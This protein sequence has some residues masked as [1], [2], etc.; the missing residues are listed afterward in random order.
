MDFFEVART[1]KKDGSACLAPEFLVGEPT[2]F[3]IRG[4]AFYAIWDEEKGRWS[5]RMDDVARLVDR[6]VLAAAEKSDDNPSV[7]LMRRFKSGI[8]REFRSWE[9]SMFDHF[10]PLD[11]T[12]VFADDP[13]RKEDYASKRL[14]YSLKAGD[15]SA[16]DRLLGVLYD[17]EE[18]RKIIWAIGSVISGDSARIQKFFVLYGKPG[19]GKSTI[20]NIIS[21]LFEGYS[22]PF[23]SRALVRSNNQFALEAF[24]TNPLIAID[25][26][27]DMSRLS[28]NTVLNSLV[29]HEEMLVNEK[30]KSL[31][32]MAFRTTLFVGTNSPVRITDSKSG[33]IR[34]LIDIHPTGSTVPKDTYE[35]LMTEISQTRG[36]IAAYCRD[37]YNRMGVSYYDEY[38]PL[39]MMGDTDALYNFVEYNQEELEAESSISLRRA[40]TMYK[41]YCDMASVSSPLPMYVFRSQFRSYFED[42]KDRASLPDGSRGRSVYV[43]FRSD[44][45][46]QKKLE[47]KPNETTWL[48]LSEQPSLLDRRY[49]DRPAQY[50]SDEGTPLSRW[51]DVTTTLSDIDTRKEHYVR[52]PENEIVIDFDI[53]ENGVKSPSRNLDAASRWPRTY[54]ERSRGGGGLHLHYVY[55]GDPER[56]AHIYEP[57]IEVKW[58]PGRSALRRR[59]SVCN[60]IPPATLEEGSLPLKEE[61]MLNRTTMKDEKSLRDLILRNLRKEIHPGTK[62]S[63]DFIEK[64]LDDAY[65]QGM[66]YDLSDMRQAVMTFALRSTHHSSYCLSRVAQMHF[67]SEMDV[68]KTDGVEEGDIVFFDC[69]V[70]P[71]LFLVNWKVR[72]NDHIHRMINPAPAEIEALVEH[73]L[74]GFNNR[75]YD[76]HILYGRMMGYSNEQ[77]F[78]LSQKIIGNVLDAGFRN[79]YDLSYSDIYDFSSKKQSLKKWEIE[80]GIHHK[81]LGLPWD[82]PVPEE[83]WP[84]VSAYCDNDVRAT[85]AVFNARHEDWT[86]RRVLADVAGMTPNATNRILATKII[87]GDN[88]HPQ[89]DLVYTDL[90]KEFPGYKYEFG[91]SSYRG[92]VTGEGGYVYAEPGIHRNVALLDIASMHPTSIEVLNMFGPYTKRFSEIK[93]ARIAIKHGDIE[94]AKSMLGGALGPYLTDA[95]QAKDLAYALKIVINSVYGLTAAS[96]DNAFR[97]PRNVDNI[98]AKRG[99]LFMIDLKHFV[100]E[101]GFT[102]AHIKTDSIKIPDATPEIISAVTEFGKKYGYTFEHE[103]TYDRMC[104]LND[105]V[106]IAHDEKGW[107]ATGAQFLHPY[108]F[109]SLFSHEEVTLDDFCETKAVTTSLVLG[110]QETA[111]EGIRFVGRVG[112]F[113]PVREG[114]F[115]ILREKEGKYSFASGSKGYKWL[116]AEDLNGDISLVDDRYANSLANKARDAISAF[117]DAD[118]FLSQEDHGS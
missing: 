113:V 35:R 61:K 69:E 75:R 23:D 79:A 51:D 16:F 105:A 25:H 118:E 22:K 43:G 47:E 67:H 48:H 112:R 110:D 46:T 33:I 73:R 71:N 41:E 40:Y 55:A 97:D 8:W 14:P 20:L 52:P 15:H 78:H 37:E 21:W 6:E 5:T 26:D 57:G 96:F 11:D 89:K 83:R 29:S 1:E 53:C 28:D 99:A 34:R 85:E 93:A 54:A 92:E 117:G 76:N 86:A 103:A 70:F 95:S 81:E 106:Y 82:M 32:G 91:V 108:V 87:F 27:G 24:K 65:S 104:L 63:I 45:L 109:K 50:S 114:G 115:D 31:Y 44:I 98:C 39:R 58:Y 38:R 13:V 66:E 3:M 19:S 107:H 74:I 84:E 80:L 2:D 7:R 18:R 9:S 100:Q 12:L 68:D 88:R 30:N 94:H 102:V 64:I 10:H 72:G 60:D 42:Y 62:P 111:P 101:Q 90:S 56:L 116:E 36:E 17:E 59:L 77:L 49:S 4:G